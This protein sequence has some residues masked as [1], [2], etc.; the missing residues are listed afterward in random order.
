[1]TETINALQDWSAYTNAFPPLS[2][3]GIADCDATRTPTVRA[4]AHAV[5]KTRITEATVQAQRGLTLTPKITAVTS[6]VEV[7]ACK[8]KLKRFGGLPGNVIRHFD[9]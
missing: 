8:K 2:A 3:K 5:H 9:K 4:S 7:A 6:S 1:M